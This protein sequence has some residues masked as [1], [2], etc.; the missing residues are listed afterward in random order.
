MNFDDLGLTEATLRAVREVGYE[1][2][3]P[4]QEQAIPYVLMGRDVLGCA[5]TGTG[6]TASFVLPMLD[7][8][9]SSRARA[10]MP[11]CLIIEPTRELATQVD[12]AFIEYGKYHSFESALLIGGSSMGDQAKRLERD[13]DVLIATPGRLLDMIERGKVLMTGVKILVID[14]ADRMLDMGFIPDIERIVS[15]I[16]TIRQ[17]LF[18]SATM[19]PEIRKL[20]DAFLM[21]PREI[22]V[23]PPAS[24]AAMVKDHLVIVG[25]RDKRRVLHELLAREDVTNALIFCNRKRDIDG[26][27]TFL[28][29]H[30]YDT[31]AIH[32]DLH[33]SQRTEVLDRFRAGDLR[34]LVASD[35]AARGLDIEGLSHVFNFDVPQSAEDYV[36]RIGRTGRAGRGG[37]AFTIA[38]ASDGRY[39]DGIT[40]LIGREI[41]R[42]QSDES[43]NI[44][45]KDGGERR[46]RRRSGGGKTET[47]PS[48]AR[49]SRSEAETAAEVQSPAETDAG[50]EPESD[51]PDSDSKT[52]SRGRRRG[53]RSGRSREARQEKP[54]AAAAENDDTREPRGSRVAESKDEGETESAPD[55]KAGGRQRRSRGGRGRSDNGRPREEGRREEKPRKRDDQ[56]DGDKTRDSDDEASGFGSREET[57]AFLLRGPR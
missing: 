55:E 4:I 22:S 12:E 3:T 26:L 49:A 33:Q 24:P 32:G 54:E 48:R 6:K 15:M 40:R 7:I 44:E 39:L 19:P 5:Q 29:G 20:A 42:V 8:L 35:V 18:F 1:Q 47:G 51:S 23:A 45:A 53:G 46:G 13:I 34:L 9:D 43:E 50:P 28:K 2:P 57:P 56:T 38:T 25:D 30:G 36:H 37:R 10:R 17:T 52:E 31:A 27:T 41:P 16:P 11:R 14:E 21:N